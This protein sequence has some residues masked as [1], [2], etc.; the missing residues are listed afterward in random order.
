MNCNDVIQDLVNT[1]KVHYEVMTRSILFYCKLFL[2]KWFAANKAPTFFKRTEKDIL[3]K[4]TSKEIRSDFQRF[5]W[6]NSICL[7]WILNEFSIFYSQWSYRKA[8]FLRFIWCAYCAHYTQIFANLNRNIS[9]IDASLTFTAILII[10]N[11]IFLNMVHRADR[12]I[13]SILSSCAAPIGLVL[14]AFYLHLVPIVCSRALRKWIRHICAFTAKKSKILFHQHILLH[15]FLL[16]LSSFRVWILKLLIIG[17]HFGI[18]LTG[19]YPLLNEHIGIRWSGSLS[20]L[21]C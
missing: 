2:N 5:P 6:V 9:P 14:F 4:K 20:C 21:S 3:K 8:I 13:F 12:R 18:F 16:T 15:N 1:Q 10:Y 7:N 11:L 17:D 19:I